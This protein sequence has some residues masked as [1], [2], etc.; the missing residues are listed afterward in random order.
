M[1]FDIDTRQEDDPRGEA[2]RFWADAPMPGAPPPR[3]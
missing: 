1:I 2:R 3:G